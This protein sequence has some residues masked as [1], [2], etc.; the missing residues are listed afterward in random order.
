MRCRRWPGR[1]LFSEELANALAYF[2]PSVSKA[3][4]TGLIYQRDRG[5]IAQAE[6]LPEFIVPHFAVEILRPWNVLF[7]HVVLQF[8]FLTVVADPDDFQSLSVQLLIEFF[9]VRHFGNTRP[10]PRCPKID[11]YDFAAEFFQ[12]DLAAIST[13]VNLRQISR[14]R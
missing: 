11:Q 3:K 1:F 2:I 10:A 4:N 13:A 9:D 12:I 5:K 14:D 6:V 8:R 7:A